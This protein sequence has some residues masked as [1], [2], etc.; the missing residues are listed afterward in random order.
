M[1]APPQCREAPTGF[2]CDALEPAS[3]EPGL[4]GASFRPHE[5][6]KSNPTSQARHGRVEEIGLAARRPRDVWARS[7][8]TISTSATRRTGPWLPWRRSEFP[9]AVLTNVRLFPRLRALA[10][11]FGTWYGIRMS[12]K[13]RPV[14]SKARGSAKGPTPGPKKDRSVPARRSSTVRPTTHIGRSKRILGDVCTMVAGR[15]IT[16]TNF[17]PW[18]TEFSLWPP[19][20]FALTSMLLEGSGAYRCAVSPPAGQQWPPSTNWEARVRREASTWIRWALR[21]RSGS[22]ARLKAHGEVL[23]GSLGSVASSIDADWSVCTAVLE[24]HAMA[25]EACAGVGIPVAPKPTAGDSTTFETFVYRANARLGARGTLADVDPGVVR[26][27]PKLRTP[28]VGIT[29]RSLSQHITAHAT[30]V[31][32]FWEFHETLCSEEDERINLLVLPW[33]KVVEAR[34]FKEKEGD[35][36]NM[37]P[38]AFGFFAYDPPAP[39]DR[40]AIVSLVKAA[41]KVATDVHGVILPE[42]AVPEA[43]LNSLQAEL[44]PLGVK[45]LIAGAYGDKKNYAHLGVA[46]RHRQTWLPFVQ[47]KHHRWCVDAGQIRQ[48]NL[49]AVLHPSRRWWEYI[50]INRRELRFVTANGWLTL[51]HLICEDLARQDPVAPII[52]GVGPSLIIALLMDGPQLEQR[53]PGRYATVFADDPGSSVLSITSVGM[54]ERSRPPGREPSRVVGLWKD[55]SRGVEELKLDRDADALLLSLCANWRAEWSADGRS[56]GEAT[57]ELVL[58]AVE[59]IRMP[60]TSSVSSSPMSPPEP[61]PRTVTPPPASRSRRRSS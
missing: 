37:D 29:L 20:V 24:L 1:A 58:S 17:S 2:I 6:E 11:G 55:R 12:G 38:K 40:D 60:A 53:W 35:L 28:Q 23:K 5:S 22:P 26:V 61:A 8:C 10:S 33:P 59:Q 45:L 25:D 42:C 3:A 9:R 16:A 43:E 51:C 34:S 18:W 4:P 46:A 57:S 54:S 36:D 44:G 41:T 47:N 7:G 27:L 19:N 15:P 30:E 39:F 49:G 56:D 52:R 32:I 50:D 48:Y 31:D 13:G 14:G 21:L